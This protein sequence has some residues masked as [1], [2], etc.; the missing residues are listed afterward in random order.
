M[1]AEIFN[2]DLHRLLAMD[3]MWKVPGRYRP[4][5]LEFE[6][7]MSDT[8]KTPKL[9]NTENIS[10]GSE[11]GDRR[12]NGHRNG[13]VDASSFPISDGQRSLSRTLKDQ[14]ELSI[15]DNLELFI[16]RYVAV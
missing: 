9:R 7:I 16:N 14:R 13:H 12:V 5:P 6:S 15:K 4:V 11:K 10:D 8:F 1:S 3:D 2:F